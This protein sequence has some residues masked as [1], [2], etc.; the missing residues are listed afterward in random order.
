MDDPLED[1]TLSGFMD[2][3]HELDSIR[4]GTSD[5]NESEE[6]YLDRLASLFS[7]DYSGLTDAQVG[8]ILEDSLTVYTTMLMLY[9][10]RYELRAG[11]YLGASSAEFWQNW[12]GDTEGE[13]E[14]FVQLDLGGYLIGWINA[15]IDDQGP[16]YS[17]SWE[18]QKKRIAKGVRAGVGASCLRMINIGG[19]W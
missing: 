17:T 9:P 11:A 3:Y 14:K 5:L 19:S 15:W 18:A 10:V 13:L 16:N 7:V 8:K 4:S 6:E 1:H 12:D 2:K